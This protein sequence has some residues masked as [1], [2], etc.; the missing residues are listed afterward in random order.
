M[1]V[2]MLV[3]LLLGRHLNALSMG[4]DIAQSL[5]QNSPH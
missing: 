5:G 3:A 4:D 1:T 2:G